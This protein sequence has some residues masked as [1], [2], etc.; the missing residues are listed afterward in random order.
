MI[1]RE[2]GFISKKPSL[3]T[4]VVL[5]LLSFSVNLCYLIITLDKNNKTV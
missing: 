1:L 4:A 5:K 3:L 2:K